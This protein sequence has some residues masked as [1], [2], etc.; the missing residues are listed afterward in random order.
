MNIENYARANSEAQ[1]VTHELLLQVI[2]IYLPRLR[3]PRP[4][5]TRGSKHGCQKCPPCR[6][7]RFGAI[8]CI[9]QLPSKLIRRLLL[10]CQKPPGDSNIHLQLVYTIS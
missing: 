2:R 6:F 4:L 1:E 5:L 7:A 10:N 8:E 3:F 9:L